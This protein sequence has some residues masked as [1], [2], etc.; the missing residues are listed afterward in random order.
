[1]TN[2]FIIPLVLLSFTTLRLTAQELPGPGD[3]VRLNA[4]CG[5][6][7]EYAATNS[8]R[9]RVEGAFLGVG[10]DSVTLTVSGQSQS[11][12]INSMDRFEVSQ[13]ERSHKLL[14]GVIGFVAGAGMAYW[15]VNSGGS[16]SLCD[17]DAN[18]DAIGSGECVGAVFL[19]GAVGWGLG[20]IIGGRIHTERWTQ[21]PIERLRVSVGSIRAG[22][23]LKISF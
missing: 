8:S 1:M 4:P 22:L 7:G 23:A 2:S 18:Q 20:Y 21:I 14:G 5:S 15:I 16:T 13:G 19:G 12:G 9:C 3:R 17:R 10:K 11:F 6:A